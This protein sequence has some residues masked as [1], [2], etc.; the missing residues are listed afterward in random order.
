MIDGKIASAPENAD[1]AR[2][3]HRSAGAAEPKRSNEIQPLWLDL[4]CHKLHFFI[5]VITLLFFG[6]H[7]LTKNQLFMTVQRY[8]FYSNS[9]QQIVQK[10]FY[11]V[12][13]DG[14]KIRFLQQFTTIV[15]HKEECRGCL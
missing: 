6:S 5:F 14:A 12:V 3:R 11:G 2:H 4:Y 15:I 7:V 10:G 8:D 1:E 9:Q 13:Y